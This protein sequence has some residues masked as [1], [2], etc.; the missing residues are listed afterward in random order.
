MLLERILSVRENLREIQERIKAAGNVAKQKGNQ[1]G[2]RADTYANVI[3]TFDIETSGDDVYNWMYIWQACIGGLIVVG[4][5]WQEFDVLLLS[6]KQVL[7]GKKIV[8][9][10]H[11]LAYEFQYLKG[12]YNFSAIGDKRDTVFMMDKRT[13][14]KCLVYDCIEFRCSRLLSNMS[15]KAFTHEMHVNHEKLDGDEFDYYEVRYPW[16]ELTDKQLQYC[17][18]DVL[19]LYEA[20]EKKFSITGDTIA[21]VPYTSTGYVRRDAKYVTRSVRGLIKKLVPDCDLY[22]LL[23]KAFRGGNTHANRY[24]SNIIL[25][26]VCSY[27]RS[28]SYPDVIVNCK[29][30][31]T[32]FK[33]ID[34]YDFN[35][36]KEKAYLY[37]IIFH[38]VEIKKH[39]PIPYIC[40]NQYVTIEGGIYDNGRVLKAKKIIT[41]VTDID[42]NIIIDQ[43]NFSYEVI[44]CYESKYNYLPDCLRD[45][46]KEYY[47]RKTTLKNVDGQELQYSM[48]KALLNAIYGM[49]AQDPGKPNILFYGLE[50][51]E[52]P[53]QLDKLLHGNGFKLPYQW[54]VWVSAWGRRRLQDGIDLTVKSTEEPLDDC[55]VY[56]DTDSVKFVAV[57]EVKQAFEEYNKMRVHDS[58]ESGAYATDP[59]GITHY[60]GVYE[61][62]TEHDENGCYD[63][64][65]TMGSKRYA[66]EESGKLHIT[67]AGVSKKDGANELGSID[68]FK[69][70]F[71][72][73][74]SGKTSSTYVDKPEKEWIE[75]EGK[76]IRITPYIIIKDSTYLLSMTD[77]YRNL[78][79]YIIQ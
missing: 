8:F 38:D 73:E 33:K 21:T 69:D 64:F 65:K 42:L 15:L 9:Y 74:Q 44:Q 56:C 62:E 47:K 14:L 22:E 16:T 40:K 63:K 10:V 55:M 32:P 34:K 75:K 17:V 24:T 13:P 41:A 5:T 25:E 3:C 50:A 48:S 18:N 61:C 58:K 2:K 71:L 67:I 36:Q 78:L 1:S 37:E 54:G 31:M 28:S 60:M 77:E 30:P 57:P 29:F 59:K 23:R 7:N 27:D 45:L 51:E 19:G 49:M 70:G 68:N 4:R 79:Q 11:N 12:L 43:Y 76:K 46:T 20:L 66:Y 39:V 52:E 53:R 6:I 35:M 72:F 26:N